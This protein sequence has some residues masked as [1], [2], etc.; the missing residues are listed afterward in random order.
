M[1]RR[2]RQRGYSLIELSVAILIGLFL[3]AGLFRIVQQN[4]RASSGQSQ[5]AQLQDGER[6]AMTMIAGV[7]QEA[8]YFPDPTSNT[9]QSALPVAAPFTFAGQPVT[10]NYTAAAPGDSISVRYATAT[11]DG[12]L[13][14]SG[15]S[16]VS[17]ANQ[18]YVNTFSVNAGQLLCTMN[19]TQYTLVSGVQNL[20][21]LYGVKTDFTL[22]NNNVDTYL[23]ASQMSAA[24]WAN[25]IS[26]MVTLSFSNPLYVAGQ[27]GQ[28][29]QISFQ[30]VVGVMNRSG[31]KV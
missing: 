28:P 26:V 27:T 5:L 6:L 13:N 12:V 1:K 16:N 30:R 22:D 20:S 14:C 8:G 29:Q 25:V 19:G 24:N 7:I 4:R 17:G 21:I 2:A 31:V 15:L 3:L 9:A 11:A 23:N 10:G 18:T